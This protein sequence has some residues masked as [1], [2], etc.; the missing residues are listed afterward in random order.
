MQI[1]T[2]SHSG[3]PIKHNTTRASIS[4]DPALL[5]LRTQGIRQRGDYFGLKACQ[6]RLI[7]RFIV[8]RQLRL[9]GNISD[10][11]TLLKQCLAMDPTE[12]P[13]VSEVFLWPG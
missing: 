5:E 2:T 3:R 9:A 13:S 1:L 12:T 8:A 7:K 6:L 10:G 11:E 4:S